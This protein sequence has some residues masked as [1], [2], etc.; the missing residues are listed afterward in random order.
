MIKTIDNKYV[1]LD[2]SSADFRFSTAV[3]WFGLKLRESK[4]ISNTSQSEIRKLAKSGLSNDDEGYKSE[5]I[6]L[7]DA[8][9]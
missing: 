5:F 3:A 2:K 7:V 9:N 6:R 8:V 1:A 4:L